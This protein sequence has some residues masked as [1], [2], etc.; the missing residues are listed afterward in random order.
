MRRSLLPLLAAC[1]A[2]LAVPAGA[3]GAPAK[4]LCAPHETTW[5]ACTTS[6]QRWIGLCGSAAQAL[7]YRFGRPG[8]VE[9]RFPDDPADGPQRMVFAHY[10]RF[11][12]DRVEVRFENQG[13][14]YVLFDY[15]EGRTRRT[16]VRVTTADDRER[17]FTCAGRVVSRLG[18]LRTLLK[19][20]AESALNGGQCP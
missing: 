7:Q 5:L 13:N 15:H 20:D 12:T 2:M 17:E 1:G 19:C 18:E 8:A 6:R 14:D 10:A 9:L 3:S 4:G 16:G 11:Q